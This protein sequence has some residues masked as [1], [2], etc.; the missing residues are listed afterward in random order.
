MVGLD[1]RTIQ[2]RHIA[3]FVFYKSKS[4]LRLLWWPDDISGYCAKFWLPIAYEPQR[5]RRL[6]GILL[7]GLDGGLDGE[8]QF[9]VGSGL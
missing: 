2:P 4:A 1:S 5:R 8:Y 7:A 6:F 9:Y 3:A